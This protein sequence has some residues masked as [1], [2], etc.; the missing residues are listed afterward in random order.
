M[1]TSQPHTER[2]FSPERAGSLSRERPLGE[3][4][5]CQH[6]GEVIGVYEPMV[7]LTDEQARSTSRAAAQDDGALIGACYHRACYTQE[8]GHDLSE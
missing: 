5:R 6:C 7:V 3:T 8:H 4:L 2:R 1:D